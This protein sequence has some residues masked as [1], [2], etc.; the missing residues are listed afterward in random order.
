MVRWTWRFNVKKKRVVKKREKTNQVGKHKG[1]RKENGFY[2]SIFVSDLH[3]W[4]QHLLPVRCE[5]QL[6]ENHF[7][8][9]G[10]RH[11]QRARRLAVRRCDGGH[12][13]LSFPQKSGSETVSGITVDAQLFKDLSLA[14]KMQR[15]RLGKLSRMAMKNQQQASTIH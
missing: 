13:L 3:L 2:P 7:L 10:G 11:L 4:E 8:W 14:L 12:V 6:S 9:D 15:S 1:S 5:E